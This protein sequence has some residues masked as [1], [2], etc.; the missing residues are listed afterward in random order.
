MAEYY[1][2]LSF[3]LTLPAEQIEQLIVQLDAS[4][5]Q[6]A[7]I[8]YKREDD[9]SLWI[10]SMNSLDLES[11]VAAIEATLCT[12]NS[13]EVITFTWAHTCSKPQL[14]GFGGGGVVISRLG[15]K[16]SDTGIW[17]LEAKDAARKALVS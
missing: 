15:A 8:D 11:L 5:V 1:T 14:D 9:N 7:G 12:F 17:V 6:G 2:Q 3:L 4:N 13:D 10:Y 16:F